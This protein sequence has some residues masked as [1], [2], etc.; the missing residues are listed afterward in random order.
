MVSYQSVDKP[1][2]IKVNTDCTANL[3][4]LSIERKVGKFLHVSSVSTLGRGDYGHTNELTYWKDSAKNTAYSISKYGGER[5]VCRGMEAGLNAIIINP[6]FILGPGFWGRNSGLFP[7]VYKGLKFYPGGING[8]VDVRDVVKT[9]ILLMERN[10]FNDRFIIN[11]ENISYQQLFMWI[12]AYLRKPAPNIYVSP[13]ISRVVWRIE[14]LRSFITQSKSK[15]TKEIAFT[16]SQ[17][18]FYSNDKIRKAIG[19]K[20]MP[21][22]E[23]IK[24]IC[25]FFLNDTREINRK[26]DVC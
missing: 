7:L 6:S 4:N 21:V 9:M 16:T 19:Y 3:V 15:I 17:K 23:S 2:M 13:A 20:F 8:Y 10:L 1:L 25:D 5:E 12:A 14:A 22:E 24:E 11:S 26:S 18:Y